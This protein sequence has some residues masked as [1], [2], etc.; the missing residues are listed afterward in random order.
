MSA[1]T[2]SRIASLLWALAIALTAIGLWFLWVD[3]SVPIPQSWG[4]RGFEAFF[5]LMFSTVGSLIASNQPRNPIGW[6]FAALG[7]ASGLQL[8]VEEYAIYAV[9][10]RPGSLPGGMAAAWVQNWIWMLA[11]G[12][13]TTFLPLLF[14]TGR[15]PSRRWRPVALLAGASI[16][17]FILGM[18]FL[19]GPIQNFAGLTNPYALDAAPVSVLLA[20][21]GSLFTIS[22]GL[23]VFSLVRRARRAVGEEREQLKWFAYAAAVAASAIVASFFPA[24][25]HTEALWV[26]MIESVAILGVGA[27]AGA[28]GV[29]I[30]R[31]R[32]YDI[33]LIINRTLVYGPLTAILAGAYVASIGLSQRLFVALTGSKS[34]AAVV[35]TTLVVASAFTPVKTRLQGFVDQ[36]FKEAPDPTKGARAFRDHVRSVV[37]V[38][39]TRQITSRLLDEAVRAFD[40]TGGAVYLQENDQLRPFHARGV[41]SDQP[42][43]ATATL[44]V[45]LECDTVQLGL[46]SLGERRNGRPYSPDDR[47]TLKSMADLVAQAMALARPRPDG[48]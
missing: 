28:V 47:E 18:A 10:A 27:V 30:L 25:L 8:L 20:A 41:W 31:Y 45:P 32:L 5:A 2:A 4:F 11:V 46:L 29:A 19:P 26:D 35:L 36:R 24:F 38:I 16:V 37:E 40:A 34:D 9:L 22:V 23:S 13:F 3:R 6:L 42:T 21:G 33:D 39:D 48:S 15:L 43:A 12:P 7:A 14:P 44:S 1:R 17:A